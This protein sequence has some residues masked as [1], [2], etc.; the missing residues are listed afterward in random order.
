MRRLGRREEKSSGS[1]YYRERSARLWARKNV[2]NDAPIVPGASQSFLHRNRVSP[3]REIF[4]FVLHD[5]T[6]PRYHS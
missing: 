5:F 6:H 1:D 3:S 4:S 2:Q